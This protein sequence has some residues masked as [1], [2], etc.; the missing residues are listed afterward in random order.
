MR[1]AQ[2]HDVEAQ[3][4]QRTEVEAVSKACVFDVCHGIQPIRYKKCYHV[5]V[6]AI[7]MILYMCGRS[8]VS[9]RTIGHLIH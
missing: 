5:M 2:L 6:T 1:I 9:C 7:G 8:L 3:V 4:V